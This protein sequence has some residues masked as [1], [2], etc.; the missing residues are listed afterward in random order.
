[1]SILNS[2]KAVDNLV[3]YRE[4]FFQR[5]GIEKASCKTELISEKLRETMKQFDAAPGCCFSQN[6]LKW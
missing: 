1:M 2:Q 5:N 6:Y 4:N 3:E